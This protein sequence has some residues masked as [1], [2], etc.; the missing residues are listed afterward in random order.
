MNGNTHSGAG[1]QR[2]LHFKWGMN[3]IINYRLF[4]KHPQQ[5]H[6]AICADIALRK[7][8]PPSQQA[9]NASPPCLLYSSLR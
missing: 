5:H 7:E 4:A 9:P 8:G 2:M 3:D 6:P 1:G